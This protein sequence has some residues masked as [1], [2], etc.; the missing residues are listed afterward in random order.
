MPMLERTNNIGYPILSAIRVKAVGYRFV[1][2]S[3]GSLHQ[4]DEIVSQDRPISDVSIQ[5]ERNL[6]NSYFRMRPSEADPSH[7]KFTAA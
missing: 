7:L 6:W 3:S 4:Y 1:D 5:L 2:G